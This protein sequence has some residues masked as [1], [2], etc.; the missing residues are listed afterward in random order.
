MEDELSLL[1]LG[2]E[3]RGDGVGGPGVLTGGMMEHSTGAQ[4][5]TLLAERFLDRELDFDDFEG[6][7]YRGSQPSYHWEGEPED[8]EV[9]HSPPVYRS[10]TLEVEEGEAAASSGNVGCHEAWLTSMPPL[11]HRQ[12]ARVLLVGGEE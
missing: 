12:S 5:E 10:L 4:V 7:V 11:I 9:G 1:A 3:G 2:G 8:L 6:P